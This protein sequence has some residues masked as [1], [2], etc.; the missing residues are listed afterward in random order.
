MSMSYVN[1]LLGMQLEL[2]REGEERNL[3]GAERNTTQGEYLVELESYKKP[4]G[5]KQTGM[6]NNLE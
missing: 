6:Q 2:S 4:K 1:V 5:R 3:S